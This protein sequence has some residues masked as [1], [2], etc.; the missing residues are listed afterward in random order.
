[1]SKIK[2][3]LLHPI[4]RESK[5]ILPRFVLVSLA[6]FALG[7][8]VLWL[9]TDKA[10][11]FYLLSGVAGAAVSILTDFV[12]H[13]IWTFSQRRQDGFTTPSLF[14]RFLKHLLSKAIGLA[15]AFSI[16]ALGTQVLRMHYLISN[17]A[18]IAA[19]FM[20]NYTMSYGWIWARNRRAIG[21][22]ETANHSAMGS[23]T[24]S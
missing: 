10:H 6:S 18:G 20:W 24:S 12:L 14:Q 3:I 2:A 17:L 15:I 19:A 4:I 8:L 9:L 7:T 16:L 13:E 1:M 21:S 22:T 11:W 5:F 23:E